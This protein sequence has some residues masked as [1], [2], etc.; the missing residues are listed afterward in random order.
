[1]NPGLVCRSLDEIT[2]SLSVMKVTQNRNKLGC[3]TAENHFRLERHLGERFVFWGVA[4]LNNVA[5][6][7]WVYSI[8]IEGDFLISEDGYQCG[9]MLIDMP[10]CAPEVLPEQSGSIKIIIL[11]D[12]Y[13]RIRKILLGW[14]YREGQDFIHGCNMYHYREATVQEQFDKFE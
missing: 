2:A 8:S 13:A 5:L 12:D 14:G 7:Q 3:Q 4:A 10:I 6:R 9:N 11:T 1:M